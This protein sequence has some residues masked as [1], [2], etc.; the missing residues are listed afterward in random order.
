MNS[1]S[2]DK[3]PTPA[4]ILTKAA[5][6]IDE[7]G[8]YQ[9]ASQDPFGT[10]VC[11][12]GAMCVAVGLE[13]N[14]IAD[15]PEFTDVVINVLTAADELENRWLDGES[16]TDWNDDSARTS[17]DVTTALRSVADELSEATR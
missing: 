4:E 10:G 1:K 12:M 8:W 6:V 16:V 14:A 3:I 7:R 11:A 5:A 2:T 15:N 9:G 17:E 13:P